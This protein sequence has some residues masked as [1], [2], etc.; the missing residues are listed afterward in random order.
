MRRR[1]VLDILAWPSADPVG[2]PSGRRVFS[3]GVPSCRL[4][5]LARP[6]PPLLPS[7]LLQSASRST[8]RSSARGPP[9]R[10]SQSGG[11]SRPPPRLAAQRRGGRPPPPPPPPPGPPPHP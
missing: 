8:T 1:K 10:V 7:R 11:R 9:P 4:P 2:P 5:S 3:S 6:A